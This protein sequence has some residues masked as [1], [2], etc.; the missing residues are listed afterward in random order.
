LP[1][2]AEYAALLSRCAV[3]ECSGGVDFDGAAEACLKFLE[4]GSA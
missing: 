2:P 3:L 1:G 4:T